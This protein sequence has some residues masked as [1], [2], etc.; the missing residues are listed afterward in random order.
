MA[1]D[2]DVNLN[3]SQDKND[4]Q[5]LDVQENQASHTMSAGSRQR[6]QPAHEPKRG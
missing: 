1:V 3:D 5:V 4:C 2:V 6:I